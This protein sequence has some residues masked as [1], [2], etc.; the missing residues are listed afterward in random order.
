MGGII[1]GV[2]RVREGIRD[3][4]LTEPIEYHPIE[5]TAGWMVWPIIN[6][7]DEGDAVMAIRPDN[8]KDFFILIL[9]HLIAS[10]AHG[11]RVCPIDQR[12]FVRK[13]RI[14]YCS[15]RCTNVATQR[16]SRRK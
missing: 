8:R 7:D 16:R 9:M 14:L 6:G 12:V 3:G 15:R 13:G 11:L 2:V 5:I 4:S 10:D 1:D